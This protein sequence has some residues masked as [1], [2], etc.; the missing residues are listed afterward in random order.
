[1]NNDH[2]LAYY[3][4]DLWSK[5]FKLSDEDIHFI[6]FGKNS[7]NASEWKTMIA[8]RS[9]LKYQ[10]AFDPSFFI[11]ILEQ[12]ARDSIKTKKQAYEVLEKRGLSSKRV[13]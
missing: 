4:E 7:T 9:T 2:A 6:Y 10:H 13:T 5:G 12:I 1:M 3:L 8:V 11:A